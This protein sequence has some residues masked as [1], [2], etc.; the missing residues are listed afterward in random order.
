MECVEETREQNCEH[1]KKHDG[2]RVEANNDHPPGKDNISLAMR[3]RQYE[4][5]PIGLE[6]KTRRHQNCH[7]RKDHCLPRHFQ[8]TA[9]D[10]HQRYERCSKPL[11]RVE[12]RPKRNRRTLRPSDPPQRSPI[13]ILPSAPSCHTL[14]SAHASPPSATHRTPPVTQHGSRSHAH[15]SQAQCPRGA[16]TV[17]IPFV[18]RAGVVF[19]FVSHFLTVFG[20]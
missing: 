9:G 19:V 6:L 4:S 16:E 3:R 12:G 13:I 5:K 1:W 2:Q 8:H 10:V 15:V 18:V 11:P 14:Q 20:A 7:P 17:D